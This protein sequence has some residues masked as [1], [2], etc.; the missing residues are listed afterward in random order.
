MHKIFKN[1]AQRCS[2]PLNM[3]NEAAMGFEPQ[4]TDCIFCHIKEI[5]L[6]FYTIYTFSSSSCKKIRMN[7]LPVLPLLCV[8][9]TIDAYAGGP[10]LDVCESM[11]P[12]S[13][14]GPTLASGA[15]PYELKINGPLKYTEGQTYRGKITNLRRTARTDH[16]F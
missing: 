15:P 2:T 11:N 14:H 1:K 8:L 5:L 6:N 9:H 10:P 3:L 4:T 12:S 13:G 16:A 7:L